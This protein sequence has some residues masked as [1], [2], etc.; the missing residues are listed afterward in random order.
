MTEVTSTTYHVR[1]TGGIFFLKSNG[2]AARQRALRS[3]G[4]QARTNPLYWLE[5]TG[6]ITLISELA[7]SMLGPVTGDST[8]T[9]RQK[10]QSLKIVIERHLNFDSPH[11]R[12]WVSESY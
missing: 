7:L 11:V 10:R 4:K 2:S 12:C 8:N 9:E 1:S 6:S 5:H 3:N